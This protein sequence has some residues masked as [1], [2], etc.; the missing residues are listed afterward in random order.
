MN[1]NESIAK[2]QELTLLEP[3]AHGLKKISRIIKGDIM[4]KNKLLLFLLMVI[5]LTACQA[6]EPPLKKRL[7]YGGAPIFEGYITPISVPIQ[8]MYKPVSIKTELSQATY[9]KTI[10]N[11]SIEETFES[12]EYF[13]ETKISSLG[14]MLLWDGKITKIIINGKTTAPD[15][16]LMEMRMLSDSY[17]KFKE[18][19]M[20]SPALSKANV[21]QEAID[22]YLDAFKKMM[23]K[24][25]PHLPDKP[26]RSG[27]YFQK[28]DT[29]FFADVY[30]AM[31]P[32]D[33]IPKIDGDALGS[34]IKGWGYYN[35]KKVVVA[36]MDER[37]HIGFPPGPTFQIKMNGYTLIDPETFQAIYAEILF[38]LSMKD[39]MTGKVFVRTKQ[40]LGK[41]TPERDR[42]FVKYTNGI[43]LDENTGLEWYTGPDESTKWNQAKSWA[44]SLSIDGDGWR[45][46]SK[47]ELATLYKKG[48]GT[49]N[50]TPLLKTT[51]WFVWSGE[52]EG[53]KLAWLFGFYKGLEYENFRDDSCDKF[54]RGFAVRSRR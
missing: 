10:K 16:P 35:E 39:K 48:A 34:I 40:L 11:S 32:D 54:C 2:L 25:Y 20:S 28:I 23:K 12:V 1:Q 15:I 5:L 37:F 30:N 27:D 14:D 45:M 47:K 46:P 50:M 36:S 8:P 19:E 41:E 43:V 38:I 9:T 52:A 29:S 6:L 18:V 51:G 3:H 4:K 26:V 22:N 44:E 53:L 31:F 7:L 24:S 17:G 21:D 13:G 33:P 42:N 49:R